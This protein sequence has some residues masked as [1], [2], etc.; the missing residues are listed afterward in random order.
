MST[1]KVARVKALAAGVA[2]AVLTLAACGESSRDETAASTFQDVA[3]GPNLGMEATHADIATWDIAIG[4]DGIGL[5]PGGA[6]A[7]QGAEIYR[8]KCSYCH[9]PQGEGKPA[10]QL[11]GGGG[12]LASDAPV[13]TVGSYWPYATTLFDYIRRAMPLNEPQSLTNEEV[14][15]VSAH[16]LRLN[17][18]IGPDE[19]LDA[20]S[21]PMVKMPN[22]D[23][24]FFVYPGN[25]K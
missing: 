13:K 24:F 25:L 17:G 19:L 1:H 10:D 23:N 15:A 11:A 9:G 4:P 12:T 21:L 16:I 3:E 22:R 20:Q 5:P 7:K 8:D 14:Y 18:L 2:F 6:T